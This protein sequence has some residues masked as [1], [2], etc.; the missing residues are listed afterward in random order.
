MIDRRSLLVTGLAAT[1][2]APLPAWADPS[3]GWA[4]VREFGATGDGTTIDTAAID[5]QV[6]ATL[7]KFYALSDPNRG[8][9]QG[10]AGS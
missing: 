2:L 10:A 7:D 4:D 5:K 1:A 3:Q 8:L 6:S 9:A